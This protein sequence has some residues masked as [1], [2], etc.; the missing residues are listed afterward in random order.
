[1]A[2]NRDPVQNSMNGATVTKSM[3]KLNIESVNG[4]LEGFVA[5]GSGD[6]S[7][8]WGFPLKD[9]YRMGLKFYKDKEGKAINLSY[10]DKLRLVA[11]SQQIS[12]GPYSLEK[13]PPVGVLDVIGRDRRDAWQALGAMKEYEAMNNFIELLDKSCPLFKPFVEA[14]KA[15]MEEKAKQALIEEERRK[16]EM[17]KEIERQKELEKAEAEREAAEARKR[18]IQEALNEQT[19]QPFKA[20]AEEQYPGNPEQQAILVRQLQEQHYYQYMQQ[21]MQQ[22]QQQHQTVE[23]KTQST[24]VSEGTDASTNDNLDNDESDDGLPRISPPSMWTRKDIKDFKD[25]IRK[26][27]G[28]AIIKV[29]HG[30]TVTVRVP[31]HKDGTCLYWEF[32]TDSYDIGFGVYF[33]WTKSTT[34]QVSVHIQDSEEEEDELD[35]DDDVDDDEEFPDCSGNDDVEKGTKSSKIVENSKDKPLLSS[36][37]PIFRR[38]CQDEVYAGSHVYPG[39]GVYLLKFDN[40]YSLWR[41]KTLYYRVYYTT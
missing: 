11:Y 24:Q 27:G 3:E 29:G 25:S 7:E 37:V 15:D 32:A 36:I 2:E 6:H 39:E 34:N 31:T 28:D 10:Q 20:Y 8:K 4:S 26:E 22:Q 41:S 9:L 21:L 23:T 13:T 35:D 17:L 33:E 14:Q 18:Q 38:D 19:F 30:E 12:H 5:N 40:S 16:N 1:M